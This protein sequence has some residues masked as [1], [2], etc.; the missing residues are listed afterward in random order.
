MCFYKEKP[1]DAENVSLVEWK[2][3]WFRKKNN[4]LW[5]GERLKLC[6]RKLKEITQNFVLS[7]KDSHKY[8]A[9]NS[10]LRFVEEKF[11][12]R[13]GCLNYFSGYKQLQKSMRINRIV[14]HSH[15]THYFFITLLIFLCTQ[16][17]SYNYLHVMQIWKFDVL[18][19]R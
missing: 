8:C 4:V 9:S 18:L 2:E 15:K 19:F 13:N 16:L 12:A 10:N 3:K 1:K 5:W 7:F 11:C 6:G 14:R 17:N